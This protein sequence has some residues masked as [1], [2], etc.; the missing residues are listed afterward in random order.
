MAFLN[1]PARLDPGI[2]KRLENLGRLKIR[3]GSA[4]SGEIVEEALALSRETGLRLGLVANRTGR[5]EEILAAGA[6]DQLPWP[7]WSRGRRLWLTRRSSGALTH[8]DW[9]PWAVFEFDYVGW[10]GP[11]SEA[12]TL[13]YWAGGR[14]TAE[15]EAGERRHFKLITPDDPLWPDDF[16]KWPP[17]EESKESDGLE[18]AVLAAVSSGPRA[19]VIARLE[20]L[21]F[22]AR[23][24]GLKAVDHLIWRPGQDQEIARLSPERLKNL[25][26]TA[27]AARTDL[28]V[29]DVNLSPAQLSRL[30]A[31]TSLR[32]IDRTQL[33]LDIFA[34]RAQSREGRL[35]VEAAQ[36][37]YLLPRLSQGDSGL[38]RLTGGI[39]ARGPGETKLEIDRRR[40]RE[41]LNRLKKRLEEIKRQRRE[42]RE[43][44]SKAGPPV[45]SIVGYTNAG[46]STLL[47]ALTRSRVLAENKLFATLDPVSRQLWLGPDLK[48][49]LT[50]TV[51]FIQD[52]PVSLIEAFAAT[53]EEL[54]EADLLLH[55]VDGS[56]PDFLSR[57]RTVNRFLDDRGLDRAPRILVFNKADLLPPEEAR[58]LAHQQG[59][60]AISARNEKSLK[61]LLELVKKTL[62]EIQ[63]GNY[64]V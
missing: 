24:A 5:L 63:H 3:P 12:L 7:E 34:Q 4:I 62:I 55:L 60:L 54:E 35:Q 1:G 47:N 21:A 36:L 18:P 51:G 52:L 44:R 40:A 31:Q 30:T 25:A 41:R 42:R 61:P 20:E 6:D 8:D 16:A 28:A 22:L 2:K 45:V 50:D 15:A 17:E 57:I 48:V 58:S 14:Q 26:L 32:I 43:R 53:L 59:G 29:F 39:G 19:E 49:V 10:L 27:A 64:T 38:S 9:A 33:I 37:K 23:T 46:K 11:A 13:G 56:D